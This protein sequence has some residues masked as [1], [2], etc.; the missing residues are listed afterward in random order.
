MLSCL[1]AMVGLSHFEAY[2]E[3]C[4]WLPS[5]VMAVTL[6]GNVKVIMQFSTF[7]AVAA[8]GNGDELD[9][10]LPSRATC[11]YGTLKLTEEASESDPLLCG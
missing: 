2:E 11:N 4:Q 10:K 1:A 7:D 9:E 5:V 6:Y 3:A 8:L